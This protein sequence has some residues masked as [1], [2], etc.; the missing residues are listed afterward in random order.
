MEA[1]WDHTRHRPTF[2]LIMIV[3]TNCLLDREGDGNEC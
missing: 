3:E 2:E 1:C